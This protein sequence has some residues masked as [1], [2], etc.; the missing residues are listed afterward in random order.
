MTY[1]KLNK[2]WILVCNFAFCFLILALLS[3]C[4]KRE[5]KNLNSKGKTIIC[6][7]DSITFG[8]GANAGEDFPTQLG[9]LLGREVINSGVSGDT[10][11][12]GML[13]LDK[14]VI[15]RDPLL[16]L[17]E[18]GGNDFIKKVPKETTIKNTR[19]FIRRIQARGAMVAIVDI[20]AGLFLRDYRLLF[21]KIAREE[22]CIFIPAVLTKL[23]TNPSMKSD[24]LH[25][26]AAGYRIV[27]QR[28]EKAI[29]PY[30]RENAVLKL[31]N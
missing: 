10:S 15:E 28:I 17:I 13:R 2:F 27:A 19:E 16:V 5:I 21:A 7:G 20:S 1:Q 6:F 31:P 11:N 3:G 8:Y 29:E 23:I 26:N 25:P 14:E 9:K 30:L 18:F 24:F 22:G 4:V 12:E